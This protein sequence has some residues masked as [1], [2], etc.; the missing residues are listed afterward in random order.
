MEER[1]NYPC[2]CL[3][4]LCN[5]DSEVQ[6]RMLP[7]AIFKLSPA[8]LFSYVSLVLSLA[9]NILHIIINDLVAP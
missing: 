4:Y 8:V 3:N 6:A 5:W 9:S 1:L 7:I 2:S